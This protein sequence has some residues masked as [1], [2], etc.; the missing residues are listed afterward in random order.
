MITGRRVRSSR[1]QTAFRFRCRIGT[2]YCGG[3]TGKYE[4]KAGDGL[5]KLKRGRIYMGRQRGG[6]NP[7]NF[8]FNARFFLKLFFKPLIKTLIRVCGKFLSHLKK[9][10]LTSCTVLN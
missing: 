5:R 1:S 10:E 7:K 8:Q 2:H 9:K 6:R 4:E 3:D